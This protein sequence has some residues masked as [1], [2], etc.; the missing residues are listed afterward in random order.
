MA[1]ALPPNI[2]GKSCLA[3]LDKPS[4]MDVICG[5]GST[6]FNNPGNKA[7]RQSIANN[8]EKYSSSSDKRDKSMIVTAI[9]NKFYFN[10]DEPCRFI[11][12]CN[13]RKLWYE[14]SYD[15]VRQKV[16]Q[17]I[18]DTLVQ[19]DSKRL[20]KK[21]HYRTLRE[22]TRQCISAKANAVF[23]RVSQPLPRNLM[24]MFI[25]LNLTT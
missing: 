17:T 8:L 24:S 3:V 6:S 5:R 2:R 9:A 10:E 16:G 1:N 11:R 14:L 22:S 23:Q 19:Q 13:S 12:F 21:K 4:H 18:R 20:S 7:F 15:Q 25:I